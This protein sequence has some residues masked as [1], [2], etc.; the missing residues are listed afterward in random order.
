MYPLMKKWY[1]EYKEH[2]RLYLIL[3]KGNTN[4]SIFQIRTKYIYSR[5]TQYFYPPTFDKI[6]TY[7]QTLVLIL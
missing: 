2:I 1:N 3:N 4:I 6:F 5:Y 7:T